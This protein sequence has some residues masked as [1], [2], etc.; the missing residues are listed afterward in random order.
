MC[1]FRRKKIKQPQSLP[2]SNTFDK[3]FEKRL[4]QSPVEYVA[5]KMA[6]GSDIGAIR[7]VFDILSTE[8]ELRDRCK[9]PGFDFYF[10]KALNLKVRSTPSAVHSAP[11]ITRAFATS[12]LIGKERF[13][14]Q[15]GIQLQA[16]S[17]N[18]EFKSFICELRRQLSGM[19]V[20]NTPMANRQIAD[21]FF[22]NQANE[23]FS[24]VKVIVE[25]VLKYGKQASAHISIYYAMYLYE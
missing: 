2:N 11:R 14:N 20:S 18:Q 10:E 13:L 9:S 5:N 25:A 7:N 12:Q 3:V 8:I 6:S 15:Y 1:F 22:K 19:E 24:M 4:G 23:R 16:L 17:K 21:Y